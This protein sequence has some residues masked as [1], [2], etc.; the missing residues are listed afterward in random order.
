MRSM[1]DLCIC[2]QNKNWYMEYE[3]CKNKY[4][5]NKWN[6]IKPIVISFN[7]YQYCFK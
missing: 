6:E 4:Y 3:N 5:V 7:D 2:I 1:I